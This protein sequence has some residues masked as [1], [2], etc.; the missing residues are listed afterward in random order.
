MIIAHPARREVPGDDEE[1]NRKTM[2]VT[3]QLETI[4]S[5]PEEHRDF[6]RKTPG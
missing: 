1:M 5:L 2:P 6:A 4:P 3:K